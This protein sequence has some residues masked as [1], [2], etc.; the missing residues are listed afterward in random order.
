MQRWDGLEAIP[1]DLT[2]CVATIGF[3]DGVH[4]G[5]QRIIGRAVERARALGLPAVVVTFDPHPSAVVRPG[6]EPL[7][8]TTT[9][10]KTELMAALGV[11]AVCVIP[12]T[13]D[14]SHLE[15][16][17]F[18]KSVLADGL[19]VREVV[20][21]ANFRFGRRAAG[22]VETLARLGADD[23]FSVEA[24][25]MVADGGEPWSSTYV[26]QRVAEGD[27]VAAEQALGRPHRVEGIVVHGDGRGRELGY[28]TAN[29]AAPDA[30]AVPADGVYAGWFV[31]EPDEPDAPRW[32][33]AISV[34]TNP[35]FD[36]RTRRVEAYVLDRDVDLYDRYVAVE[37]GYLLRGME[38]FDSVQSL[39]EAMG[40]D[41]ARARE[42]LGGSQ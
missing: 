40:R 27:V 39:I 17:E 29:L 19:R 33:A 38:R 14:F 11:D 6:T 16:N 8:L 7:L 24:V 3:F 15:P 32:P 1:A 35:T 30:Y 37:F 5:H 13:T 2:G 4:R 42:L 41:V 31:R 21:G 28:P 12:F 23:G 26:R 36:G 18:A 9:R 10:H 22:D 34:G 25:G 20:V